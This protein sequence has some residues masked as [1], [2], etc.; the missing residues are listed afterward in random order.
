MENVQKFGVKVPKADEVSV[1][2]VFV[3]ASPLVSEH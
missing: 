3:A 1:W 2:S